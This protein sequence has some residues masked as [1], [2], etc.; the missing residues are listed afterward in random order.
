ML[1]NTSSTNTRARKNKTLTLRQRIY[2]WNHARALHISKTCNI[3]HRPI[4]RFEDMELD[5]IRAASKGGTK[6][7]MVHK[8]CNRMKSSGSLREIQKRLGVK[9]EKSH[10]KLSKKKSKRNY[11]Y[12]YNV[13][14]GKREKVR[15]KSKNDIF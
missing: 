13:W 9:V 11:H 3:C 5:H 2:I 7:A 1:D 14:T 12:E 15:N 10:R 6:L 8:E 4:T